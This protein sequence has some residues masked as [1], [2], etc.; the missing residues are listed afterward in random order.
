MRRVFSALPALLLGLA[1][2]GTASAAPLDVSLR[3]QPRAESAA[4]VAPAVSTVSPAALVRSLRPA[5]RPGAVERQ[6]MAQRAARAR[7]A[8][9]NDPDIQGTAVGAVPGRIAG[10]GIA[11]AV[12]VRS[13]A[14]VKLSRGSLMDCRTARALKSWVTEGLRPA[15]G[16]TGGG[17]EE[18]RVLAHYA[19]RS[20][21][22][23]RGAR[24]S[25]HGK[26]RAIDIGAIRLRDGS[27]L[28]VLTDWTGPRA[29]LM[30]KLHKSACGPFGTV[31]GPNSD[32]FHRD[33]FHFDTARYRSGPYCR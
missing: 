19:C 21:N 22:S 6:A 27:E 29:R 3:P 7:G 14:G 13:V 10:C 15:V 11:D 17:V 16:T 4:P 12:R 18:L 9:C 5:P 26:G 28:T 24:I 23:Q 1:L 33:H 8:V 31:L 2:A 20:R 25:E 30:R 32:R